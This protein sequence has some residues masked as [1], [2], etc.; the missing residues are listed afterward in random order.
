MG[1]STD[2]KWYIFTPRH[3]KTRATKLRVD[4]RTPNGFWRTIGV[5]EDIKPEGCRNPVASK[6][7][8]DFYESNRP[9]GTRTEW[10]M[11]E[12]RLT[13]D[14]KNSLI[15]SK[16]RDDMTVRATLTSA[17]LPTHVE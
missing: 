4:R 1:P 10:K 11:H 8:L 7:V 16:P 9:G 5:G 14:V 17:S 15:N 13:D 12:Y 2:N 6:N 3:K